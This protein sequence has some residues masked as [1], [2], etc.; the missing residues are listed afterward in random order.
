MSEENVEVVRPPTGG[1]PS[2]LSVKVKLK[3]KL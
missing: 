2:T 3:K 1:D